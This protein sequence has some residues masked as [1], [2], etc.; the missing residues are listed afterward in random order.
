MILA[1]GAIMKLVQAV[2]AAVI[3]ASLAFAAAAAPAKK[4]PTAGPPPQS[5]EALYQYCRM[6]VFRKMGR[7]TGDG[8]VA[9]LSQTMVQ[10]TDYCV[11]NH[12]K[13]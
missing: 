7:S 12:G 9:V 4:K 5:P 3:V 6:A 13:I 10:Q 2:L 1:R 11:S 8:R